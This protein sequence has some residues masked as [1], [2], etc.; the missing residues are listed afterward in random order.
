MN[1]LPLWK[2]KET[3]ILLGAI[4][5][6]TGAF[7]FVIQFIIQTMNNTASI[8]YEAEEK[9]KQRQK[10][11]SDLP[12]VSKKLDAL[13]E[14]TSTGNS[15]YEFRMR[16][17]KLCDT[18]NYAA[19][20]SMCDDGLKKNP[21]DIELMMMKADIRINGQHNDDAALVELNDILKQDPTARMALLWRAKIEASE[22]KLDKAFDDLNAAYKLA[23]NYYGNIVNMGQI[24]VMRGH[25]KQSLPYLIKAINAKGT[26]ELYYDRAYAYA[27]LDKKK[28]ASVDYSKSARMGYEPALQGDERKKYVVHPFMK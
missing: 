4:A 14:G 11:L 28:L 10:N 26:G 7:I 22:H 21:K 2:R 13:A 12:S 1:T 20:I 24:E 8:S 25:Y 18:K 19:A 16:A 15:P 3:I 6:A 23:P 9:M 27:R 5:V 17:L